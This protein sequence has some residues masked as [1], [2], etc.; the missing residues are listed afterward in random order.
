MRTALV[1]ALRI[2][3]HPVTVIAVALVAAF[4]VAWWWPKSVEVP[5]T[6]SMTQ[7]VHAYYRGFR[8]GGSGPLGPRYYWITVEYHLAD[9]VSGL[10]R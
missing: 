5:G 1:R 6:R 7:Q 10:A 3:A 9:I 8:S 4:L 2:L